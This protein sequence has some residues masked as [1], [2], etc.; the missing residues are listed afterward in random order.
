MEYAECL[1]TL[2]NPLGSEDLFLP[3]EELSQ[4]VR[5]MKLLEEAF[6]TIDVDGSGRLSRGRHRHFDRK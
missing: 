1:P 4:L 3:G 2:L 5:S 6:A